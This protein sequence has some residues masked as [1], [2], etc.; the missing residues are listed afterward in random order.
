MHSFY[1]P[2]SLSV[3]LVIKLFSSI[4]LTCCCKSVCF[5]FCFSCCVFQPA[6]GCFACHLL[7]EIILFWCFNILNVLSLLFFYLRQKK[8]LKHQKRFFQPANCEWNTSWLVKIHKQTSSDRNMLHVWNDVR[9]FFRWNCSAIIW[10]SYFT[11]IHS[12]SRVVPNP[13]GI[14]ENK[15]IKSK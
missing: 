1:H 10:P 5:L 6:N 14:M 4:P 2:F 12:I 11:T 15:I 3:F 9:S 8:M 7:V 13:L